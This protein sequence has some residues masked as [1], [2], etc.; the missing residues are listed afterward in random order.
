M[1]RIVK[2]RENVK[3]AKYDDLSIGSTFIVYNHDGV[4]M[5]VERNGHPCPINLATGRT[6]QTHLVT[7]VEVDCQLSYS[8]KYMGGLQR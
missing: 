3:E 1:I 8:I 7:V 6:L 5:K 2:Q 4:Y